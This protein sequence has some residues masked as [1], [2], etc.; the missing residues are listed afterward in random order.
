MA[1]TIRTGTSYCGGNA[2]A[3]SADNFTF[4]DKDG[5]IITYR[6]TGPKIQETKDNGSPFDLTDASTNIT[7]LTF[8]PYG[9]V[10]G[11]DHQARVSIVISGSVAYS[12]SKPPQ[13]F[14][15]ETGATMRGTDL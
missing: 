8:Y 13:T 12:S 1:R 14:V 9:T 11:D 4:T 2:C 7:S 3:T 10:P 6:L 5:H 15:V